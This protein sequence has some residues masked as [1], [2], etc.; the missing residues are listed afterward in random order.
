MSDT[1]RESAR[2]RV[3]MLL[4]G[5]VGSTG[6]YP[7]HAEIDEALDAHERAVCAEERARCIA[8]VMG[9]RHDTVQPNMGAV[10]VSGAH[11]SYQVRVMALSAVLAAL[12]GADK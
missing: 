2:A 11:E 12:I 1:E 3:K 6:G 4:R 8:V 9:M 5:L 7:T 10:V